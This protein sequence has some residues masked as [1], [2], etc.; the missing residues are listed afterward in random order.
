VSSTVVL[1]F[2]LRWLNAALCNFESEAR[3]TGDAMDLT[4]WLPA[5]FLLGLVVLGAMYAFLT[6]CDKV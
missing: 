6:V 4:V 1:A 3:P 5:M 2:R